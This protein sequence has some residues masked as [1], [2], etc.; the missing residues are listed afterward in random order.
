M[1]TE[2]APRDAA[3]A[4]PKSPSTPTE[5]LPFCKA[6]PK[7]ELHAH[8]NGCVRDATIQQLLS[9]R[10][11]GDGALA[12]TDEEAAALQHKG[13]R[14]L[15]ECFQLFGLIHRITTTHD[16]VA[17]IAEEVV[18]DFRHVPCT[19]AGMRMCPTASVPVTAPVPVPVPACDAR[20]CD[21]TVAQP[22]P[23]PCLR[24][25]RVSVPVSLHTWVSFLSMQKV[26][27]L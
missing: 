6:L 24:L 23:V 2:P 15:H 13:S 4:Q 10:A 1:Q 3:S 8:L 14:S 27:S 11:S 20:A 17:R 25:C 19:C 26:Q 22:A 7:A 21:R 9:E 5:W 12:L 18:H 16:A